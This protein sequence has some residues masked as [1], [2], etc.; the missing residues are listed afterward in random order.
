[1]N[2]TRNQ[3]PAIT[4]D[5]AKPSIG[6]SVLVNGGESPTGRRGKALLPFLRSQ[7]DLARIDCQ[8]QM[9]TNAGEV[10]EAL[11]NLLRNKPTLLVLCGGDGTLHGF[12][13]AARELNKT[14]PGR[15]HIPPLLLLPTGTMNLVS[16]DIG[17]RSGPRKIWQRTLKKL[18]S[19]KKLEYT[20][21]VTLRVNQ[22]PGFIAGWG[23]PARFLREYT[24]DSRGRTGR[25]RA[26]GLAARFFFAY[27][28]RFGH[29][30]LFATSAVE[31]EGRFYHPKKKSWESF[32]WKGQSN[33]LLVQTIRTLFFSLKPAFNA[34]D[35]KDRLVFLRGSYTFHGYLLKFFRIF[36]HIRID[37]PRYRNREVSRVRIQFPD[38]QAWFLDGEFFE[39][40]TLE[41]K[42]GPVV[43]F[44]KSW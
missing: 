37:K 11:A 34:R 30:G 32:H 7:A 26:I 35:L 3:N 17:H 4:P 23:L 2:T 33:L 9:T 19:G 39:S 13:R 5:L 24:R 31:T 16:R 36:F 6:I 25:W 40:Q 21:R 14:V 27:L 38:T 29:K 22:Q 44:V 41:I 15:Y 42:T 28:F 18:R 10:T 43:R 20:P 8:I 12:F 1:M